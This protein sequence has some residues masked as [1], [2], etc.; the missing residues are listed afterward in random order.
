MIEKCICLV[1]LFSIKNTKLVSYWFALKYSNIINK[2]K[3]K[4]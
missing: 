1:T 4:V 2:Y 3:S